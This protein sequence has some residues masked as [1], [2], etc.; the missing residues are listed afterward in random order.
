MH[1]EV[2]MSAQMKIG[3]VIVA[4]AAVCI[5]SLLAPL[6]VQKSLKEEGSWIEL[7]TFAAYAAALAYILVHRLYADLKWIF[8]L[9][10]L[11]LMRE[12][13]FD[14]RFTDAK[15]T[16]SE[17]LLNTDVP[18]LQTFYGFSLLAFVAFVAF[19]VV[20]IHGKNFLAEA[21][22]ASSGAMASILAIVAAVSSKVIDGARRKFGYVGVELT[23]NSV[24][25][26]QLLEEI[27]ELGIPLFILVALNEYKKRERLGI[28]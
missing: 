13:D 1:H 10:A 16:K 17:F 11:L 27:L 21:K 14:A 8:W 2:S 26:L 25:A 20:T 4:L 22:A 6:E 3:L 19:K 5:L 15:I 24:I 7:S 18:L 23:G 12:L 9:I 28:N